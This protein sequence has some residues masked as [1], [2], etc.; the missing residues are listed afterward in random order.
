[1]INIKSFFDSVVNIFYTIYTGMQV[2]FQWFTSP[3]EG[4]ILEILELPQ[5]TTIIELMFGV[6]I[7]F[8]VTGTL[9]AWVKSVISIL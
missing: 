8:V 5:N 4:E 3:V 2:L 9:I 7:V 1:M 6:G